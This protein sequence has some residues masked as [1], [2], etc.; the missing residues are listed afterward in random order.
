MA[1]G[2]YDIIIVGS[3]AGGGA[4]AHRLAASGKKILLLERGDYLPRSRLNW[5]A[6]AV[7]V[8]GL[9][10]ADETWYDKAGKAFQPGLHYFVGGNTKVYGAALFRLRREDFGEVVH[11]SGVS[12]AWPLAYEDFE[13]H[14]AA[15][16]ALFHVHGERGADPTEPPASGPYPHPP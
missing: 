10:E 2:A 5:D 8:D 14:Y 1:N 9:Y 3:G 12:P 7:F 15:A 11:A 6:K 13:P 16:E 4:L